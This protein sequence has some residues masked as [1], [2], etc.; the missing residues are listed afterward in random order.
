M[1]LA[2]AALNVYNGQ[3]KMPCVACEIDRFHLCDHQPNGQSTAVFRVKDTYLGIMSAQ[4]GSDNEKAALKTKSLH[5]EGSALYDF[6]HPNIHKAY[7]CDTLH[8][9][10]VGLCKDL[11]AAVVR[12]IDGKPLK[13]VD[14]LSDETEGILAPASHVH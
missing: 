7:L 4:M 8:M 2:L 3:G 13:A 6:Y 14:N 5:P 1:Y 10:D 9:L 11:W 12:W